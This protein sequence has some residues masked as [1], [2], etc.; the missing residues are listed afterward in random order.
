MKVNLA[1]PKRA[2]NLSIVIA[3]VCSLISIVAVS[4]KAHATSAYSIG[5]TGPGGGKIFYYSADGF[6]CGPAGTETCNYLEAALSGWNNAGVSAQ[7][8]T[9]KWGNYGSGSCSPCTALATAIGSG[10]KNTRAIILANNPDTNT[11]A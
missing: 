5:D 6:P 10:Y 3:L 4:E 7:D 2:I 1:A 11:A 9:R 8:P